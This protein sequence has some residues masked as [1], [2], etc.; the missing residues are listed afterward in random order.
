MIHSPEESPLVTGDKLKTN[1]KSTP[2]VLNTEIINFT[3]CNIIFV[4]NYKV[5]KFTP[6][7][8]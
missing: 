5:P 6:D 8:E 3:K 1:K 2:W 4:F 7:S